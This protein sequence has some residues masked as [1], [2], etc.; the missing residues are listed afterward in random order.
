MKP[1]EP[2]HDSGAG[3]QRTPQ[4]SYG[5]LLAVPSLARALLGMQMARIA[6]SM[7]GLALVLFTLDR[8]HSPELAGLVTFAGLAPGILVS[9]IAGALLDRHGRIWLITLDF[10]IAA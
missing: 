7:V 8:Y 1:S 10:I 6:Q 9:P 2:A 4:P 3:S 5:A